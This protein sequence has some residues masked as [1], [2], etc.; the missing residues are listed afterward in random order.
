MHHPIGAFPLGGAPMV[1]DERLLVARGLGVTRNGPVLP[2]SLPVT[3]LGSPIGSRSI[4][5]LPIPWAEEVPLLIAT[6][7]H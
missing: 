7:Q 1:V 3:E 5:I 2:R 6:L 4:R